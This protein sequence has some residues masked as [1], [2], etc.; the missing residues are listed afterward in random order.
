ML[1]NTKMQ[2]KCKTGENKRC[3]LLYRQILR[4]LSNDMVRIS[5]ALMLELFFNI[6]YR[7]PY[8]SVSVLAK[9]TAMLRIYLATSK[10][11]RVLTVHFRVRLA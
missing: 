10:K 8:T 6:N 11:R 9:F 2:Q 4:Y 3:T 5:E 1:R 7:P